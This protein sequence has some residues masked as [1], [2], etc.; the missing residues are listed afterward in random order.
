[1]RCG[2]ICLALRRSA[3]MHLPPMHELEELLK[4]GSILPA[5]HY[6]NSM[7]TMYI[8]QVL[9]TLFMIM[10]ACREGNHCMVSAV[11]YYSH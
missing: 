4:G 10:C 8:C 1:M 2:I 5:I 7:Y 6:H 9:P 3:N 11:D